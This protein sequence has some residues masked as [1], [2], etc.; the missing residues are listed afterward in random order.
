MYL[1]LEMWIQYLAYLQIMYS[2]NVDK[3]TTFKVSL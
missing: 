1:Q 3:P 2:L